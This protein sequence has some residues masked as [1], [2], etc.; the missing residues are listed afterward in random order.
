[1]IPKPHTTIQIDTSGCDAEGLGNAEKL[2]DGNG[3]S[4]QSDWHPTSD[5]GKEEHDGYDPPRARTEAVF[6]KLRNGGEAASKEGRQKVGAEIDEDGDDGGR[7]GDWRQVPF[8]DI[9]SHAGEVGKLRLVSIS[10]PGD[11]PA[12]E[13]V[14]GQ[15]VS[16]GR[17]RLSRRVWR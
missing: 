5:V 1:M 10:D 17:G 14:A 4:I 6:Q 7:P 16:L 12:I 11:H 15:E 3:S 9:A 8:V 13:A 2:I